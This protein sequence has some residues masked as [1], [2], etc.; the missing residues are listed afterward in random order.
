VEEMNKE[1]MGIRINKLIIKKDNIIIITDRVQ[2]VHRNMTIIE[3]IIIATRIKDK[4]DLKVLTT[5]IT[6]KKLIIEMVHQ[7]I[8]KKVVFKTT[9]LA[10]H[11][12]L[13]M[14]NKKDFKIE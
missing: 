2:E 4:I 5:S 3:K 1:D 12:V 11:M 8:I 14:I 9:N 13:K 6:L 7:K 10:A